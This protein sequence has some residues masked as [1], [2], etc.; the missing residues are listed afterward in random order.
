MTS[1][2]EQLLGLNRRNA[3]A[4][5]MVNKIHD[6]EVIVKKGDRDGL[7]AKGLQKSGKAA[8]ASMGTKFDCFC[9]QPGTQEL[10]NVYNILLLMKDLQKRQQCMTYRM[11]FL[12]S[13]LMQPE[14]PSMLHQTIYL[15]TTK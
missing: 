10:S 14:L 7:E 6:I 9:T 4:S 3:N 15:H 8:E 12:P 5:R 1:H 11:C 13:I 2:A